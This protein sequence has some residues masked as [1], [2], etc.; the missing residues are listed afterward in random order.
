VREAAERIRDVFSTHYED[1][2]YRPG[3]RTRLERHLA[4]VPLGQ[5]RC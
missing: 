2:S 5:G 4:R 3:E 1:L